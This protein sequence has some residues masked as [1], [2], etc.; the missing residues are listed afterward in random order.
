MDDPLLTLATNIKNTMDYREQLAAR[1][2][3][4]PVIN[5]ETVKAIVE[6]YSERHPEEIVGCIAYVKELK[7]GLSNKFAETSKDTQSR[8]MAE[9]PGRLRQG[10][11]MKYPEIF[12]DKNL[13]KFLK[14]Y[15]IFQVPEVL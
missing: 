12:K 2:I 14:L 13:H 15:P 7:K 10:L 4:D 6:G 1:I 8:H 5:W 9:I 3:P 11:V